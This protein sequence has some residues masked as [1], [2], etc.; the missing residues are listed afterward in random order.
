MIKKYERLFVVISDAAAFSIVWFLYYEIRVKS[1]LVV[2]SYHPDFWI[3]SSALAMYWAVI[4]ALLGLYESW[5]YKSRVEEFVTVAKAITL[6]TLFLFSIVFTD[7]LVTAAPVDSRLVIFIYWGLMLSIVG[8]FRISLR[9]ILKR[10]LRAGLGHRATGLIG[11]F[12]DI[13]SLAAEINKYPALGYA[14]KGYVAIS[15]ESDSAE[16]IPCLGSLAD[17][18]EILSENKIQNVIVSLGQHHHS[19]LLDIIDVCTDANVNIKIKPDLYEI[20][21]G[22]VRSGQIYGVPLMEL[23]PRVIRPW[24]ESVKRMMDIVVSFIILVVTAPLWIFVALAIRLN[25]RGPIVYSQE[26]VGKNGDKFQMH[27]FRSMY[28]DA[29]S[30]SGPVWASSN[31]PRV[32]AVGRFLRKTR[33]D[34]IPQFIN[35][36]SGEMSLV[37]PRPERPFFVDKF[38]KEIPLYRRRLSVKPGITGWAQ[39]KQGYDQTID[40]VRSKIRYDLFY[41]ENMSFRMDLTILIQTIYVMIA[42]KGN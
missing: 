23:L 8:G 15:D 3:P 25:S 18:K 33:L 36:L 5:Y 24:D 17:L 37:G 19:L 14:I 41:I 12:A 16:D 27:K 38:S 7:D 9:T 40:D 6:G 30:R 13:Q 21:S 22:Q 31:D 39:V 10:F 28:A 42:G 2:Q 26:R 11:S 20:V 34:E 4:F 29:E 1:G 32:T 35:V